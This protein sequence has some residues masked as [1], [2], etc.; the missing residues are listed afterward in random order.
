MVQSLA[1]MPPSTRSTDLA[2]RRPVAAHGLQQV[3]G[4]VADGLQRGAGDL[5][6]AGGA[7]EPEQGA[8]GFGLPIGRAE[9][10]EGR[11]EV[12]V[13]LGIRLGRQR[14][15]FGRRGDDLEAVAQPLHGGAGDEDRA[16]E[17]IGAL[18]V[19]LVGDGGQQPVLGGHRLGARVENREAAGAVGGLHHAG[20]EAGL[21]DGGRLLVAGDAQDRQGGAED[22]GSVV[23]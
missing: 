21:A 23:P 17:R 8:A 10:D 15:A 5:L 9:A 16:F 1:T 4:L 3:A 22:R 2:A 19:E 6:G 11:H 12:D 20:R 13:L 18:A 14:P 7:R